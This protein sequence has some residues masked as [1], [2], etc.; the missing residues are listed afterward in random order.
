MEPLRT[1]IDFESR[2]LVDLIKL[3]EHAYARHWSTAPLMLTIGTAPKGV[4]PTFNTIDFFAIP[5]YANAHYPATPEGTY[6]GFKVPCPLAI[7]AAIAR[8]DVFVA[9]NARFEQALYYYICHLRWGWPLPK[10]WSCTAA[11]SRYFGIRASLDGSSSDLEVVSRKDERGKQFIN[12]FCKPRKYKGAKKDGIVKELWFEPHENPFGW[13]VGLDYCQIDGETEADVDAVL[14]DLPP[15]EQAAWDW[16]F[17]I[18]T[19]GVPIDLVSVERAIAYSEHF[20]LE[21]N[22]KFEAIT[23]LR[24]TQRDKVLE[25]LQQ[26]EEIDSL[27]DLR[28]KTLKRMVTSDF[29]EDLRDVIQIRLDCSLAS[30]KKLETMAR[31]ADPKDGRA[32]GGLLY[33]GAHTMRWSAKRIQIQNM[34]RGDATTQARMF[35]YLQGNS[36]AAGLG[37]PKVR[38]LSDALL[39]GPEKA[40]HAREILPW[41]DAAEWRFMRPL[42]SLS[43]SMRGFIQ[44]PYGQ[45]LIAADFSQIEARV[46]AWLA[47]CDW[48][49]AAFRN[50]DD[51]Y[52]KF[53]AEYMYGV[54]YEDCFEYKNGKR[55]VAMHFKRERQI[56]KSAVLG[57]GFGLGK[58]K[59][60]EYCDNSDLIITEEEAD[61]TISAY[62]QAHPEIVSLWSRVEKASILATANEGQRYTLGGTGVSFYVWRI[63]AER[64]WL[65]CELPSG[66]CIHYYRP[67]LEITERWGQ[68]KEQLTFRTEWNGKSYRESTYGGKL[69][70]NI[71]Q[72]VARDIMVVGGL[73]GEKAGYRAIMLVHDEVVT[74]RPKGEGSAEELCT[75]MCKQEAWVTDLPIDAEG[76]VMERY[77]K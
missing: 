9:H 1:H 23:A 3:G 16:D 46:L 66:R 19:R 67:K 58:R 39:E 61:K 22:R 32:R 62:R 8:G 69:V 21:A 45:E 75:L 31:V 55:E 17:E 12:D 63:D 56:A 41:V 18:N 47:R 54:K 5:G 30:V 44:A 48:L 74:L 33:G 77:G 49:L 71:V 6:S 7:V 25:Y 14:P 11:R 38:S 60:V 15:F 76:T 43:V 57:A 13:Q 24:P 34:K 35:E 64:Y 73:N 10:R 65:V 51:P 4:R 28:S 50:K 36:W 27:G 42:A 53:G 68:M 29:P 40:V 72:A 59:F 70:E 20:T 37:D 52:V 26:R 2:S